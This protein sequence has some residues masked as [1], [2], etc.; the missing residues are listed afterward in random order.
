M[1][2]KKK[3]TYIGDNGAFSPGTGTIDFLNGTKG[4]IKSSSGSE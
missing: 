3:K 1:Q 2:K 4:G